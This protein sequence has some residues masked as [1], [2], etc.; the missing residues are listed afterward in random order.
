MIDL[1]LYILSNKFKWG[2]KNNENLYH[3]SVFSLGI[4]EA[5]ALEI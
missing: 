5:I 2:L 4:I 1:T 3:S